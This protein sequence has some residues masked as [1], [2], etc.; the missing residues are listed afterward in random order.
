MTTGRPF[1]TISSVDASATSMT[2]GRSSADQLSTGVTRTFTW[3]PGS[4]I[5]RTGAGEVVAVVRDL[6]V[7]HLT[8]DEQRGFAA[9]R[10][11]RKDTGGLRD[12]APGGFDADTPRRAGGAALGHDHAPAALHRVAT[13]GGRPAKVERHLHLLRAL[14]VERTSDR[15][16]VV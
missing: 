13:L 5:A 2:P 10:D 8:R 14:G 16:S 6:G 12:L 11:Q 7:R 1:G 15:K 3:L 9:V 4:T